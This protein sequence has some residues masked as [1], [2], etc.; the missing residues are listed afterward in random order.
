MQ[1]GGVLFCVKTI[2]PLKNVTNKS[3]GQCA[4]FNLKD[5]ALEIFESRKAELKD[6]DKD[7]RLFSYN[8]MCFPNEAVFSFQKLYKQI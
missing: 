6:D 7:G 4:I 1:R 8:F 2:I 5:I 3:V